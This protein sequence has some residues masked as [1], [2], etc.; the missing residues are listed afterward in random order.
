LIAIDFASATATEY[1]KP[2]CSNV[3]CMRNFPVDGE[4]QLEAVYK[5]LQDDKTTGDQETPTSGER[6]PL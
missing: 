6:E 4:L 1:F 5:F 3:N 2:R